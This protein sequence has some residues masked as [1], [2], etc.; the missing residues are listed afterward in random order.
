MAFDPNP[1]GY[2]PNINTTG[3]L[4]GATGVFIPYEDL[5]SYDY[6]VATG[7]LSGDIRQLVYSVN[8]AVADIYLGLST[9]DRPAQMTYSRSASV[10]NDSIIRKTYTIVMNLNLPDT[11][12][13]SE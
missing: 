3:V 9:G 12:V 2:F 6:A 11:S 5:E 1:T 13:A 8:E 10:P 7:S 4:G